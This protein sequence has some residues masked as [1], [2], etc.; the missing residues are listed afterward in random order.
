MTARMRTKKEQ[1]FLSE[2]GMIEDELLGCL[3]ILFWTWC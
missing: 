2:S 1:V 3:V